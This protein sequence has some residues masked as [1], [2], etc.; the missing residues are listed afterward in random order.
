MQK[1]GLKK[2]KLGEHI[3]TPVILA[4]MVGVTDVPFK[5]VVQSFGAGLTV[6]EMIASNALTLKTRKALQQSSFIGVPGIRAIQLAGRDPQIVSEAAR[7]S[8]ALGAQ[9]IDLNFGC[10]VKKVV[11][12]NAG[13][14]LMKDKK[15]AA[16]IIG[17]VVKAVKLPVTIKMRTGWDDNNRNAPEIAAMAEDLGVQMITVHGR[18]RTQMFHGKADWEFIAQVKAAIKIP[19]I[20]N[21]DIKSIEDAEACLKASNADGVMI[22]RGSYGKPWLVNQILQYL[23]TNQRIPAPSLPEI[24][25]T[26]L[27]HYKDLINYYGES[28]GVPVARK[29]ISWYTSGLPNASKFRMDFHHTTSSSEAIDKITEYF[30]TTIQRTDLTQLDVY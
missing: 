26:I 29:H 9:I 7:I 14:A 23:T 18:T 4:P 13:S 11:G 22:G 28:I 2:I 16:D 20:A 19:V 8:E 3:I 15:L 30:Q 6:S 5:K 25:K 17:S 12:G 1:P 21:G 27:S 24:L 10:P